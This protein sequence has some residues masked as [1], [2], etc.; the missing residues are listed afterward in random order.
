[1]IFFPVT[2]KYR[3]ILFFSL[4]CSNIFDNH[5]NCAL[6][7]KKFNVLLFR[8]QDSFPFS[9]RK[10]HTFAILLGKCTSSRIESYKS[11]F[12]DN[13]DQSYFLVIRFIEGVL[14]TVVVTEIA[15]GATSRAPS[16]ADGAELIS[17]PNDF[18]NF[19]H[20]YV[21]LSDYLCNYLMMW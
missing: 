3:Y 17:Y 20:I 12:F 9:K 15:G 10:Q 19:D 21:A 18:I 1:M 14:F 11:D 4:K 5:S 2:P 8:I 16:V 7:L 13:I 6:R